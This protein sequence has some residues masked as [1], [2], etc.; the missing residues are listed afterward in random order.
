MPVFISYSHED[1]DFADRLAM[2]LVQQ[3]VRVWVDRWELAVGDSLTERIQAAIAGASALLVILSRAS[4]VSEWC[5]RELTAGLVRELEEKRVVVLPIVTDDCE[6]PLF[7]RDKRYADFR[8]EPDKGLKDVLAALARFSDPW[9]GR[10]DVPDWTDDWAIDWGDTD[11]KF[12]VRLTIVSQGAGYPCSVLSELTIV[13]DEETLRA[14]RSLVPLGQEDDLIDAIVGILASAVDDGLDLR[15]RLT[16]NFPNHSRVVV[17]SKPPSTRR[18][19]ADVSSRRL[20]TDTGNDFVLHLGDQ[21]R[22]I[23]HHVMEARGQH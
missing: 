20:G 10:V 6:I 18:W 23:H 17:A 2:Q 11:G 12:W 4:V 9:L 16:D 13:T 7:L 8:T 15:M 5:K 19:I 14:Y 3:G 21:V 1:R 22:Q